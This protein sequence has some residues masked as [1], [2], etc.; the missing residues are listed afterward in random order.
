MNKGNLA[1]QYNLSLEEVEW[2][3]AM[4]DTL[5]PFAT[6]DQD[7]QKA[8]LE[9]VCGRTDTPCTIEDI[10]T[11][12][13]TPQ[14]LSKV[15]VA[16][17]L[18]GL[19]HPKAPSK[20]LVFLEQQQ[21]EFDA[22]SETYWET[23]IPDGSETVDTIDEVDSIDEFPVD[24]LE[25]SDT[26][27]T[28]SPVFEGDL[29]V[30]LYSDHD[31]CWRYYGLDIETES[32]HSL[33][34]EPKILNR[35]MTKRQHPH[36]PIAML[37]LDWKQGNM[38][39]SQYRH[40]STDSS[41]SIEKIFD[42]QPFQ[43]QHLQTGTLT[44]MGNTQ[45]HK[46][47][48]GIDTH[49][50]RIQSGIQRLSTAT[51]RL[52]SLVQ[53]TSPLYWHLKQHLNQTI[54]GIGQQG[55]TLR[56]RNSIFCQSLADQTHWIGGTSKQGVVIPLPQISSQHKDSGQQRWIGDGVVSLQEHCSTIQR[57]GNPVFNKT[58]ELEHHLSKTL[59]LVGHG[60]SLTHWLFTEQFM[61]AEQIDPSRRTQVR[62]KN[63]IEVEF[64]GRLQWGEHTLVINPNGSITWT[65]THTTTTIQCLIEQDRQH[66]R[67]KK[68]ATTTSVS[69]ERGVWSWK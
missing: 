33:E 36:R 56:L 40:Q 37:C 58:P 46:K 64:Q 27:K 18:K 54:E 34:E 41:G 4:H 48:D 66:T 60:H 22:E 12:W 52:Q 57:H 42:S 3:V 50:R 24:M 8:L 59:S 43:Q 17:L 7:G 35:Y 11:L 14:S 2:V 13:D 51:I 67:H 38:E 53:D 69:I 28:T 65:N 16:W 47:I 25:P 55:E 68:E 20:L 23:A 32:I 30:R 45:P 10:E 62:F 6:L 21:V 15:H 29:I 49:K 26:W 19:S 9:A 31:Q 39:K 5:K 63:T 44:C 1:K 61:S